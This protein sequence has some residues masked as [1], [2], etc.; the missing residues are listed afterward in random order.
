MR[1]KD[2]ATLRAQAHHLDP[3][4]HLGVSGI[5]GAVVASLDDALRTHELVKVQLGKHLEIAPK[6]AAAELAAA[7]QS[8]VIQV[9]G[10]ICVLY[11]KAPEESST[12]RR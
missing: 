4:V 1:G 7:T 12:A 9:I 10:R 5:T 3:I 6:T 2:R 11:R 8:E